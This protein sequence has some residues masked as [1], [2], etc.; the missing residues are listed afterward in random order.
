MKPEWGLSRRR[1]LTSAG[2][3]GASSL[4]AGC[5]GNESD[6]DS[7]DESMDDAG[8]DESEDSGE[9]SQQSIGDDDGG[10]DPA[11]IDDE[12]TP[13]IRWEAT[14]NA[15]YSSRSVDY[16]IENI[17]DFPVR[18][19][20]RVKFFDNDAGPYAVR[21]RDTVDFGVIQPGEIASGRAEE[22]DQDI[23]DW[24]QTFSVTCP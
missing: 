8:A 11:V 19:T 6:R 5:T 22:D 18:V 17:A 21:G 9:E 24:D 13:T 23:D 14:G 1:M 20:A 2:L 15:G 3:I 12:S 7:S 16:R 4:I 10:C